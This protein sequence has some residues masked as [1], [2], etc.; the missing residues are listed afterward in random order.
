MPRI[1]R[2]QQ[3]RLEPEQAAAAGPNPDISFRVL[4]KVPAQL[5]DLGV[6]QSKTSRDTI[7]AEAPQLTEISPHPQTARRILEIRAKTIGL[8]R[9]W[10]IILPFPKIEFLKTPGDYPHPSVPG[11]SQTPACADREMRHR[12]CGRLPRIHRQ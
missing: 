1:V 4:Q 2:L 7:R 8:N 12:A 11:W 3:P 5:G 10:S 6:M 9:K